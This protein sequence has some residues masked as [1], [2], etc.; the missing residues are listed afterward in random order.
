MTQDSFDAKYDRWMDKIDRIEDKTCD[1]IPPDKKLA[2]Y[3]KAIDMYE[4][5][6][7]N[8]LEIEADNPELCPNSD[9]ARQHLRDAQRRRDE[10]YQTAYV[11]EPVIKS[12]ESVTNPGP[13]ATKAE[14][15]A[16]FAELMKDVPKKASP[17]PEAT[18]EKTGGLMSLITQLFRPR[19]RK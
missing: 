17:A 2:L 14:M 15:Q 5:L 1:D 12:S 3:D 18:P 13:P 6:I 7:D 10:Y 4:E 16:R 11:G 19:K 8:C 9:E